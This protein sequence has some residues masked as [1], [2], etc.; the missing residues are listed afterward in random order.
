MSCLNLFKNH[1][2]QPHLT[3]QL[4]FSCVVLQTTPGRYSGKQIVSESQEL[5]KQTGWVP[6]RSFPTQGFAAPSWTE[7]RA[8]LSGE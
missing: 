4:S 5:K 7:N 8:V 3:L 6:L 2:F 1:N